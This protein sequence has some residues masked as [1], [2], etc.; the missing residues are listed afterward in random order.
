VV[1]GKFLVAWSEVKNPSGSAIETAPAP[2]YL[3]ACEGA[4]E[5]EF[6][7]YRNVEKLAIHL[8]V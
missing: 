6:V 3:A 8:L 1:H 4:D 7:R 5:D 2:K